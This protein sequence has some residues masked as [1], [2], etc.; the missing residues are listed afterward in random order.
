MVYLKESIVCIFFGVNKEA[1]VSMNRVVILWCEFM[2][3][4]YL[5]SLVK[6]VVRTPS[7]IESSYKSLTDISWPTK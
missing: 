1:C 7:T 3:N 2:L 6:D 5:K 4:K